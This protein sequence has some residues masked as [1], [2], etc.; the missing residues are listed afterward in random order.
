MRIAV[1]TN[2]YKPIING[3]VN[4]IALYRQG[5][6][7]RGHE[8]LVVAP[9]Y[10]G[11]RDHEPGIL[12][13][14]SV[15]LTRAIRFP[16]SI[17]WSPRISRAVRDFHPDIVH[18]HHPFVLGPLALRMARH[19]KVPLVYT[20][21]TQYEQ[22]AHYVPLPQDFVRRLTRRRIKDF[23]SA[24]DLVTTPAESIRDLL[25]S[26]G[27]GAAPEIVI[28]PNPIDLSGYALQE[29]GVIRKQL[30]LD[31]GDLVLISIG[32]LGVEKNLGF[33]LEAFA[34]M[35]A[36]APELPLRLVLV[37]EGPEKARLEELGEQLGLGGRLLLTGSVP[38][39]AIPSYLAMADLFLMTSVSEV[40]PL[41]L[42][43]AMAA[44]V[45][46]VAVRAS[47]AVD[48]VAD[49]RD[50]LL[51]GLDREEYARAV[52]G[53]LRDPDRLAALGRRAKEGVARYA[54]DEVTSQLV[55][56][57]EKALEVA[58]R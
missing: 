58:R 44:G 20:F 33:L 50:G 15:D 12:R 18:A 19:L 56:V 9:D 48:T 34:L 13:Y 30:G 40:K 17:P 29:G 1:Y 28:L 31:A 10:Y 3:V 51:T 32:R 5:L 45:P 14:P 52:V 42:L 46:V 24:A 21:H 23:A 2:C 16:V 49:G 11:Y 47:G 6:L 43:E 27:L 55:A 53:L 8:V 39:P 35:L 25:L 41:V 37:G 26:Y 57:Y 7:G 4:A 38:H 22:Y 54:L 36:Y